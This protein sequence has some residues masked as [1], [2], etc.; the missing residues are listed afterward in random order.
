MDHTLKGVVALTL[1]A[2]ISFCSPPIGNL[3]SAGPGYLRKGDHLTRP[4]AEWFLTI[5][6]AGA[7]VCGWKTPDKAK[8]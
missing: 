5:N 2:G 3:C 7:D 1:I 6:D 4:T 8:G